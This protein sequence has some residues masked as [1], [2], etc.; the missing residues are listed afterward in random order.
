MNKKGKGQEQNRKT[1]P[2]DIG[3]KKLH[4]IDPIKKKKINTSKYPSCDSKIGWFKKFRRQTHFYPI[5]G[6]LFFFLPI[7]P[8]IKPTKRA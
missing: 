5:S 4:F 2:I 6:I 1:S 3:I 8:P 7:K